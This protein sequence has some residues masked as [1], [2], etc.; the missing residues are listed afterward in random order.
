M[1]QFQ[2]QSTVAAVAAALVMSVASTGAAAATDTY[3]E[4][5]SGL[6]GNLIGTTNYGVANVLPS[7]SSGNLSWSWTEAGTVTVISVPDDALVFGS[8]DGMTFSFTLASDPGIAG[9]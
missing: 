2:S 6:S 1:P 7:G 3:S 9:Y 5:F 4:N 8:G